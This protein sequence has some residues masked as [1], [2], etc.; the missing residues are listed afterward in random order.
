MKAFNRELQTLILPSGRI[1]A[2]AE[3]GKHDGHPVMYFHGF[4]MCRLEALVFD[5]PARRANIRLIAPDR[6]GIGRSSFAPDRSV[7]DHARDVQALSRHLG[8][9]KFSVLGVSGGSPYAL[10]C[11]SLLRK[12]AISQVD[13]LSG[14]GTFEENDLALVPT[15]S[16]VTGWLAMNTPRFLTVMTDVLVAGLRRVVKWKWVDKRIDGL[17]ET[18]K[19][20]KDQWEKEALGVTAQDESDVG[21]TLEESR[22]RLLRALFE[23][24]EQGSRGAV[25]ET[26][27][28]AQPWGFD[29][30]SVECPVK[31]WHG[32]KDVNAPIEW[33]RAMAEKIPNAAVREYEEETHGSMMK[34]IDTIFGELVDGQANKQETGVV[35]KRQK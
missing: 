21:W 15:A 13:I 7:I 4:P 2:F 9:S 8:L 16:K 10:G 20:S 34:H 24:F 35:I 31:I 25:Q 11:A 6:P 12:D 3:V 30:Q 5:A 28:L 33:V 1:L 29:L 32:K 14:M 27:L 19:K 22:K 17:V 26:A 18:A 23:P